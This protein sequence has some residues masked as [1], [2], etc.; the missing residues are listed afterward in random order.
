M[1]VDGIFGD[2]AY[3]AY[4]IGSYGS[5]ARGVCDSA[6]F[7]NVKTKTYLTPGSLAGSFTL[8]DI[9]TLTLSN[10]DQTLAAGAG[11]DTQFITFDNATCKDMVMTAVLFK[12]ESTVTTR[13]ERLVHMRVNASISRLSLT[14][15]GFQPPTNTPAAREYIVAGSAVVGTMELSC[16]GL[17]SNLKD[18]GSYNVDIGTGHLAPYSY[19]IVSELTQLAADASGM[20][21]TDVRAGQI[22]REITYWRTV[23]PARYTYASGGPVT[24][25]WDLGMTVLVTDAPAAG[26]IGWRCLQAGTFGGSSPSFDRMYVDRRI[27]AGANFN[28]YTILDMTPGSTRF[29]EVGATFAASAPGA[30]AGVCE[31]HRGSSDAFS[32]YRYSSRD[33]N[34]V[35]YARWDTTNNVFFAPVLLN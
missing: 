32:Y 18:R 20:F 19:E 34:N 15:C 11:Y 31:M 23:V 5:Y 9:G 21:L 2:V 12:N 28:T 29:I 35:Y 27:T 1:M 24:G 26:M 13:E 6:T 4:Q 14:D 10:I 8:V 30:G 7:T 3:A 25:R 17:R 16:R 22:F 33:T